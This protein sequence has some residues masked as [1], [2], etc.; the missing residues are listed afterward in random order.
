LIFW[1][2]SAFVKKYLKEEGSDAVLRRLVADPTAATSI[3]SYAEIRAVFARKAR[4]RKVS[5]AALE[6]LNRNF[7]ADWQSLVVV[8]VND[9][10]L[11]TVRDVLGRHPLRGV[12]AVH[13]ASALYLAR[14]TRSKHLSFACAD[15]ALLEAA[16]AEGLVAWN[17]LAV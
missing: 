12:D 13:L 5:A 11:P 14:Q 4:E 10:L 2:S 16:G 15:S 17:P 1:D 9:F 8:R 3:L 7:E 6:R